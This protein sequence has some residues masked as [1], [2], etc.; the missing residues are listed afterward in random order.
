MYLRM[1][2]SVSDTKF[3]KSITTNYQVVTLEAQYG[4]TVQIGKSEVHWSA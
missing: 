1:F 3:D 4:C 2:C